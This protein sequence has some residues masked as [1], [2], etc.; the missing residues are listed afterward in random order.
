MCD[1][2]MVFGEN[3]GAKPI[4]HLAATLG[5]HLRER[6]QS[7]RL[8]HACDQ[9]HLTAAAVHVVAAREDLTVFAVNQ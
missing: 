6:G 1:M 9:P 2:P 3:I 4:R 5:A 7:M 8:R